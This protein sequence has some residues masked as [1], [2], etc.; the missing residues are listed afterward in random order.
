M[1]CGNFNYWVDDPEHK[2]YSSEF[3]ELLNITDNN[4]DNHVLRPTHASSHTLCLVLAPG[5]YDVDNFEVLPI[6]YV[7]MIWYSFMLTFQ[8]LNSF[9]KSIT[10]KRCQGVADASYFRGTEQSLNE[11]DSSTMSAR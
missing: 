1:I 7:I 4:S 3:M 10:F 8:K 11:I 2:P 5:D 6:I 9:T